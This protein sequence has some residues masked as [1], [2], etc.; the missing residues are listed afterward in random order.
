M[1]IAVALVVASIAFAVTSV[2]APAAA[3]S[4]IRGTVIRSPVTPVCRQEVPC[5]APASGVV[6]V[7]LRGGSRVASATT[8]KTGRY[9]VV[10]EPGTYTVRLL[11][12]PRFGS[13]TPRTVRVSEGRF[14]VANI[15]IDTGIR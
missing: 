9:R 12:T 15:G 2:G 11:R 6:V 7:V 8:S 4:G 14:V 13:S 1:R 10:L 5:S 3:Q